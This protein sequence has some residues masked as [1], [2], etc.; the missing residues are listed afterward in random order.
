MWNIALRELNQ[1]EIDTLL[2]WLV[3]ERASSRQTPNLIDFM[4]P[5]YETQLLFC[6]HIKQRELV[7][8]SLKTQ[9]LLEA[10]AAK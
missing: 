5:C 6:R 10:T 2:S 8:L 3:Y 7:M 9:D 4:L 1:V